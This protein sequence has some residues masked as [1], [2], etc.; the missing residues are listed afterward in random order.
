MLLPPWSLYRTVPS[1]IPLPPLC[2]LLVMWGNE[3]ERGHFAYAPHEHQ[4]TIMMIIWDTILCRCF[5]YYGYHI[6]GNSYGDTFLTIKFYP[7][8]KCEFKG[9][10]RPNFLAKRPLLLCQS[11]LMLYLEYRNRVQ[12]NPITIKINSCHFFKI[13]GACT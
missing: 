10:S 13:P 6:V 3:R 2:L 8:F 12:S 5:S 4:L 1:P 9:Y 7:N 11:N